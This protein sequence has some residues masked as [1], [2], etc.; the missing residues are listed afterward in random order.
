[1]H[2]TRRYVAPSA[3]DLVWRYYDEQ[4]RVG[5][6]YHVDAYAGGLPRGHVVY[7]D[8]SEDHSCL[9]LFQSPEFAVLDSEWL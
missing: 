1:M 4:R 3:G 6:L 2:L 8:G 9:F 5:L 7:D